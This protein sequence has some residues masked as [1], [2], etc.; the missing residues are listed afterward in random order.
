MRITLILI[1]F[2]RLDITHESYYGANG[3]KCAPGPDSN[4]V[5]EEIVGELEYR[6]GED[7]QRFIPWFSEDLTT[8]L[9]RS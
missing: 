8:E 2:Y 4:A 1:Q 6:F 9:E 5:V 7:F 3:K